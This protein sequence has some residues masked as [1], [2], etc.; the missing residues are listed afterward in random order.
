[1]LC[2]QVLDNG[3]VCEYG[4]PYELMGNPKSLLLKLVESTG[5]LAAEKLKNIAAAAY[6]DFTH[7]Y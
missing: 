2:I 7:A 6:C 1:M 3:K 4:V 5:P